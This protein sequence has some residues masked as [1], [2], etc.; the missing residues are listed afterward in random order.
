MK[1][2]PL[3]QRAP[4]DQL[5]IDGAEVEAA[6]VVHDGLV[7]R[8]LI[9]QRLHR[10]QRHAN[11]GGRHRLVGHRGG[12]AALEIG[13]LDVLYPPPERVQQLI[14]PETGPAHGPGFVPGIALDQA[15]QRDHGAGSHRSFQRGRHTDLMKVPLER[16]VDREPGA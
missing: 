3:R 15:G 1:L 9:G 16:L 2:G 14:R 12:K 8:D 10:L 11:V 6:D 4:E 7:R 13:L 5:S